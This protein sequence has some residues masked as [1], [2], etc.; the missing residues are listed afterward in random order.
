[1]DTTRR[2]LLGLMTTGFFVPRV[3]AQERLP[4]LRNARGQVVR[5]ADPAPVGRQVLTGLDG[6]TTLLERY[7]GVVLIVNFFAT[8]CPPCRQELPALDA[9]LQRDPGLRAV[10]ISV[11]REGARVV[12][13]YLAGLGLKRLPAFIDPEFRVARRADEATPQDPFRLFGLPLSYVLTPGG[14]NFGYVAG[15]MD[16]SG[17]TARALLAE[18]AAA[19]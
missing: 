1:M 12:R 7:Q 17:P 6:R 15:A 14:R 8:W 2:P 5:F 16:W 3:L 9:L 4:A 19:G 10:A 11:D 18:A 13:P